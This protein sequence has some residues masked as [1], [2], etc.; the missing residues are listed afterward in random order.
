MSYSP[1]LGLLIADTC[2]LAFYIIILCFEIFVIVYYCVPLRIKSPYM[3]AFYF[4]LT[5]L[6][7][8]GILELFLRL[9]MA[10]MGY[11]HE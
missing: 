7:L 4:L 1:E 6:L 8:S 10:Q 5:M 9:A 2:L 3:I 11:Q